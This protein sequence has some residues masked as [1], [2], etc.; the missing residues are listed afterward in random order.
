VY[1]RRLDPSV[2][3]FNILVSH[4][5]DTHVYVL[6]VALAL[7]LIINKKKGCGEL[8]KVMTTLMEHTT[9]KPRRPWW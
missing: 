3:A 8:L 1:A 4:Y 5:T 7:P 9:L 6:S 2:L